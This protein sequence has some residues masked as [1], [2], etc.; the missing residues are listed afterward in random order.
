MQR[1][2]VVEDIAISVVDTAVALIS[3]D[4]VEKAHIELSEAIHHPRVGGDENSRCLIHLGG[5][6]DYAARL[7]RQ[8]LLEG[9]VSL[10]AQLLAITEKQ[11][12]LGPS[13]AQQ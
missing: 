1:I 5:F 4:Q 3:N 12:S 7:A 10:N 13:G 8:V 9:I 11:Y 6:T 2:K